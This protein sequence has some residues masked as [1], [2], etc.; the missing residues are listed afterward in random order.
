ML[1][2]SLL[3]PVMST[4]LENANYEASDAESLT[5][6]N[7][8]ENNTE[9]VSASRKN[10]AQPSAQV[11]KAAKANKKSTVNKK[12][13]QNIV[14]S[15]GYDKPSTNS[16]NTVL[17]AALAAM[18]A[19][20]TLPCTGQAK[21]GA[22]V[23]GRPACGSVEIEGCAAAASLVET[24]GIESFCPALSRASGLIPFAAAIALHGT[25]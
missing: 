1:F 6:I 9:V 15:A 20:R 13:K 22:A 10:S 5:N 11:V 25:P 14:L 16:S 18:N 4:D 23:S 24:V 2:R 19:R 12:S 21:A 7:Q 8:G 3:D 17:P